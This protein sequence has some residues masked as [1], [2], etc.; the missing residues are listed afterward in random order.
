MRIYFHPALVQWINMTD[1]VGMQS[2]MTHLSISDCDDDLFTSKFKSIAVSPHM[3]YVK[4]NVLIIIC[5]HC[6][7]ITTTDN[8]YVKITI[9]PLPRLP[10]SFYFYLI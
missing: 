4:K 3:T 2:S 5:S 10:L 9:I 7:K 8:L 6:N 1:E